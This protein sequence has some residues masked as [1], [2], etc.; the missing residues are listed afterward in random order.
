MTDEKAKQDDPAQSQRFI[1]MAREV[2]AETGQSLSSERLFDAL[3][4]DFK[5]ISSSNPNRLR[6]VLVDKKS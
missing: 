5:P 2:K 4:K 3:T 1:D 6:S